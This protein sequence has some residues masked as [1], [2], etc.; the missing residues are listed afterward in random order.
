MFTIQVSS[1]SSTTSFTL[2]TL[3]Q[4][5]VLLGQLQDEVEFLHSQLASLQL[6][7]ANKKRNMVILVMKKEMYEG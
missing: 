7:I 1:L 6:Q 5:R 4:H 3:V 2:D